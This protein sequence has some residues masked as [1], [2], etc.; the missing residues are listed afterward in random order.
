MVFFLKKMAP[1]FA[2]RSHGPVN[3]RLR[4]AP[5]AA[6][7]RKFQYN[8]KPLFVL[9]SVFDRAHFALN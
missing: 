6:Y 3:R 5:A 1:Y 8:R 7:W 2:D 4:L 9:H